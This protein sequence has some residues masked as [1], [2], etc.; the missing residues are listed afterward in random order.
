[1]ADDEQRATRCNRVQDV[2]NTAAIGCA[3]DR[4]V[5]RRHEVE[6][7]GFEGIER[8]R[9]GVM[10]LDGQT[11]ALGL[12]VDPVERTLGDVTRRHLPALLGQPERVAALA[13]ADVEGAA[14]GEVADLH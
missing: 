11:A 1:M 8:V 5:L 4:R 3:R 13:G 2:A 14:R 9:V 7:C 6:R 10:A 12:V